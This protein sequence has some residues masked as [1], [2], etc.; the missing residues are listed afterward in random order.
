M[1]RLAAAFLARA[2][3]RFNASSTTLPCTAS[4]LACP[5]AAASCRTPKRCL[6]CELCLPYGEVCSGLAHHP[7]FCLGRIRRGQGW[8]PEGVI[9]L[10]TCEGGYTLTHQVTSVLTFSHPDCTVGP[11]VSPDPGACRLSTLYPQLAP[12]GSPAHRRTFPESLRWFERF[13]PP[14]AGFTADWEL[15]R[16]AIDSFP[17]PAPKVG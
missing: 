12:A 9:A 11:G 13:G 7:S 4:K 16:R 17:H 3:S 14:L 2:C 5:K 8:A 10:P 6:L 1:R 15:G